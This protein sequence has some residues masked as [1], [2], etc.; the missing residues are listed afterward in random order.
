M[1][2]LVDENIPRMTVEGLRSLGHDVKDI[3]GA[4]DQG[5]AD[6]DLWR[7]ALAERR[8]LVTTDKGFTEYRST[9]HYG[10]LIVRLRQPNRQKIHNSVMHV[11]ERFSEEEWPNLLVVVRD[12]TMSTSR[13]GGER[14]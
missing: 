8:A 5:A 3:R 7:L 6:A 4:S 2:V 10:I 11:F 13:A 9:P 14:S 12:T 1:R